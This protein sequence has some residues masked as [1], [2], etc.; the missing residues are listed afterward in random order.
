MHKAAW[1]RL[2]LELR[3]RRV[4]GR[5]ARGGLHPVSVVEA[6]VK[7]AARRADL[8]EN[9]ERRR[10]WFVARNW[11]WQTRLQ[12]GA[13]LAFDVIVALPGDA[14]ARWRIA[15]MA[16]LDGDDKWSQDLER[17]RCDGPL[18][19]ALGTG[20]EAMPDEVADEWALDLR[21]PT[22][23]P[24]D[25]GP[26]DPPHAA[27][28]LWA[29]VG[30]RLEYLGLAPPPTWPDLHVLA[31]FAERVK[32]VHASA[33]G[34]EG[35][36]SG[37]PEQFLW[38]WTG[39]LYVRG[40]LQRAAPWL[41][42]IEAVG[43]GG[44]PSFGRGSLRIDRRPAPQ[45]DRALAN[46]AALAAVLRDAARRDDRLRERLAD[47]S[48]LGFD[49]DA[50]LALQTRALAE[51][52][53]AP[54]PLTAFAIPKGDDDVRIVERPAARDYLIARRLADMLAPAL[55]RLFEHASHA[56]RRGRSHKT[57]I[58]AVDRA[59][60]SGDYSHVVESDIED[61]FPSVD[62]ERLE[63]KIDAV[64]PRADRQTRAVLHELL[65]SPRMRDGRLEP[66]R[67]GLPV[68]SPLSPV[69]A[70]L[71]L[72]AF[73]EAVAAAGGLLFR[74]AD[75]FVILCR[76]AAEADR[77]LGGAAAAA[78]AEQLMLHPDKTQVRP[79]AEGFTFLGARFGALGL[80]PA[81]P[82]A[83]P[84][85]R[86]V[87]YVSEP[88]AWI[89]VRDEHLVVERQ[90]A[91]IGRVPLRRLRALIALAPVSL[92]SAVLERA[93]TAGVDIAFAHSTRRPAITL[94]RDD[95]KGFRR[96]RAHAERHAALDV[97]GRLALARRFVGAKLGNALAM[98][99]SRK[100]KDLAALRAQHG[101]WLRGIAEA[102]SLEALRGVEGAAAVE[103]WRRFGA[104]L[105]R[106]GWR[107]E[108]RVP[109]PA[110]R[111][112]AALNFGYSLLFA[113]IQLLLQAE[114]L[115]PWLGLLHE[116]SNRFPSLVCDLQEPFRPYV[117]ALVLRAVNTGQLR[118]DG[119]LEGAG[120]MRLGRENVQALAR[121]FER[122]LDRVPPDCSDTLEALIERQ[123]T[124]VRLWATG[125]GELE[126]FG[127]RERSDS[128]WSPT[129][130]APTA[131]DDGLT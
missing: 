52:R 53:Y 13:R 111:V 70:N 7:E 36:V 28:A 15:A 38:G 89:G 32:L 45:L 117:D 121:Q 23:L 21:L 79:V 33:R 20:D 31:H 35:A 72:D 50:W 97:E 30:R 59:L 110:D 22:E 84:S 57:C 8:A 71:M 99:E 119:Y 63:R 129:T 131:S 41:R 77:L 95:A 76:S 90:G 100:S 87:L 62:L 16:M 14:A 49:D 26:L 122:D 58:E 115:N 65:W 98:H 82:A 127:W 108:G 101:R 2:A 107:F 112:N 27:C 4:R 125:H 113:R 93:A 39:R 34:R 81:A 1:R 109:Q 64:L 9:P 19:D 66:R 78:G 104:E 6:F 130:S 25:A 17:I 83:P 37:R 61:F 11:G 88:Y 73:D 18:D 68:G 46:R 103:L 126:V 29:A 105:S 60:R 120:G 91:L 67:R 94:A 54:L 10:I 48:G 55:D 114:R 80:V 24:L 118:T 44:S 86:K 85:G 92:S 102:A 3:V 96:L 56:Y 40:D 75:D 42:L 47:E 12:V 5:A 69:L 123:V 106:P 74:Y 51:G 116:P 128:S 43:L 124:Q